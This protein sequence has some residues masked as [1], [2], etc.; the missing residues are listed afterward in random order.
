M[1]DFLGSEAERHLATFTLILAT[2]PLAAEILEILSH[3]AQRTAVPIFYIHCLGFY[4]HFT[5]QLPSA[6][7]IVDTHPDPTSTT[8]L[9]LLKPWAE[10]TKFAEDK[11]A[12]LEQKDNEQHGHVPYLLLLLHYLEKWKSDHAGLPPQDYKEKSEFKK[13]VQQGTRTHNPEGGE[14]NYDEAVAAVLKSLNP[15]S[16]SGAV[17]DVFAAT[18][19]QNLSNTVIDYRSNFDPRLCTDVIL[20]RQFLDHCARH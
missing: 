20:V 19:C 13:I 17:K 3:H 1:E 14:E 10:L 15:P 5:V 16:V 7:P 12:G 4:S 9:R 6:F 2:L 11:T 18:E 8:D